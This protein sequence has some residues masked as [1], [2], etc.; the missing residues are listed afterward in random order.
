[1]TLFPAPK[2]HR[3]IEVVYFFLYDLEGQRSLSVLQ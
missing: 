2:A 1:V 3:V